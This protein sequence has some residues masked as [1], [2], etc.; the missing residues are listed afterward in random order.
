MKSSKSS[1]KASE[2][3]M[4]RSLPPRRNWSFLMSALVSW[5]VGALAI[6]ALRT[7]VGVV[8]NLFVPESVFSAA[9]YFLLILIVPLGAAFI[10]GWAPPANRFKSF[11]SAL[12]YCLPSPI[13]FFGWRSITIPDRVAD[14]TQLMVQLT[15]F[16]VAGAVLG[17]ALVWHMR[18]RRIVDDRQ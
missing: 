10:S 3:K 15:I 1:L 13:I 8:G 6:I 9:I 5:S 11:R 12:L 17:G 2:L 14:K 18:R 16:G 4:I 7:V